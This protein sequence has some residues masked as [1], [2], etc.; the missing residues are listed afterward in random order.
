[1]A[2]LGFTELVLDPAACTGCEV[3]VPACPEGVLDVIPGVDLDLLTGGCIPITRVAAVTCPDCGESM[4][5]LPARV[6]LAPLPV[7]LVGRCPRCRQA[8]LVASN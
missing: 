3:C 1:M 7:G 2:G 8:A 5:A 6:H 4:P